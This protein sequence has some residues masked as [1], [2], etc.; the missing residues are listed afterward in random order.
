MF[1]STTLP[2]RF[3]LVPGSVLHYLSIDIVAIFSLACVTFNARLESIL[4]C[5]LQVF[6]IGMHFFVALVYIL[7]PYESSPSAQF[8][9]LMFLLLATN[10]AY[11]VEIRF[12]SLSTYL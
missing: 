7:S 8:L 2:L 12:N 1:S 6:S 11:S 10:T 4:T 5:Q 9:P 3:Y